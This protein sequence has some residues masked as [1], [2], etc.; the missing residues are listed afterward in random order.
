M[1][2]S[3]RKIEK[4]DTKSCANAQK[5]DSHGT[6]P[7]R[8]PDSGS[9]RL[10]HQFYSSQC[11]RPNRKSV[12]FGATAHFTVPRSDVYRVGFGFSWLVRT[13]TGYQLRRA[14]LRNNFRK[15]KHSRSCSVNCWDRIN[16]GA[17]RETQFGT[18]C[19]G[20]RQCMC[21]V[22]CWRNS[23]GINLR[24]KRGEIN[25]MPINPP[26]VSGNPAFKV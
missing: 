18:R 10:Y 26:A 15:C 2:G 17:H 19:T 16:R 24:T 5:R 8:Q 25:T 1:Q 12:H 22:E 13:R 3:I 7:R 14:N 9:R 4:A 21:Y 23:F 6:M 20:S 11:E